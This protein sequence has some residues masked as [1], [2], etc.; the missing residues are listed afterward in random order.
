MKDVVVVWIS[1]L[2]LVSLTTQY[3][4]KEDCDSSESFYYANGVSYPS[5]YTFYYTKWRSRLFRDEQGNPEFVVFDAKYENYSW[6]FAYSLHCDYCLD[7]VLRMDGIEYLSMISSSDDKRV[8]IY[9]GRNCTGT[10]ATYK[11]GQTYEAKLH[12]SPSVD[13]TLFKCPYC[14]PEHDDTI[15]SFT[16]L[17]GYNRTIFSVEMSVGCLPLPMVVCD[18]K[19]G[20]ELYYKYMTY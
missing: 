9:E 13:M 14:D 8:R 12:V 10:H 11:V 20:N 17:Y 16:N 1:I 19:D 5:N 7:M 15:A 4:L 18:S 2:A 3:Y 6:D